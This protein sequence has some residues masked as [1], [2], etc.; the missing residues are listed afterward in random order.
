MKV[1]SLH[2]Q[3]RVLV[4]LYF[5]KL[6]LFLAI[7]KG[8]KS[9]FL[10]VVGSETNFSPHPP[11][12]WQLMRLNWTFNC[13]GKALHS[14]HFLFCHFLFFFLVLKKWLWNFFFV[15]FLYHWR[16]SENKSAHFRNSHTA[17]V[18][19]SILKHNKPQITKKMFPKK[20]KPH[21]VF[22]NEELK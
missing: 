22:K 21:K 20:S 4:S 10:L 2:Y 7:R 16:H 19:G 13:G 6:T 3:A 1:N 14:I 17:S 5:R 11:N 18:S 12:L 15:K 8:N 9:P